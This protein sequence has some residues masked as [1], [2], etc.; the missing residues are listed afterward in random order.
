MEET[1]HNEEVQ[2]VEL[3][4]VEEVSFQKHPI[5]YLTYRRL[6]AT[7]FWSVPI[8]GL[9]IPAILS[10]GIWLAYVGGGLAVLILLTFISI[11]IGY[12]KRS[13]AL[14]ERD[15]TYKKGWIFSSMIT[16][17]FNRIQ[18]TEISRG[19]IERKYELST[20]KI[21]TAGGATSD[22]SIPGLEAEEAEQ[23][24]EFV[25]KKAAIYE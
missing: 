8:I 3:P 4:L 5:R 19:P 18:H 9:A 20:L 14:R 1:W 7:I 10:P 11:P 13:Y 6:L 25:A 22:L 16:I 2:L 24:K 17:P 15:L 21:Y 23:L 12:R